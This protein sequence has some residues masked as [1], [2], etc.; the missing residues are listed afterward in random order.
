MIRD[1]GVRQSRRRLFGAIG[2]GLALAAIAG[3]TVLHLKQKEAEGVAEYKAWMVFGP[4]C[5]APAK[6]VFDTTDGGHGQ[7]MTFSTVRFARAHGASLCHD[8]N[9]KEGR[10]KDI[11][12][13]CQFDHPGVISVTTARGTSWF[14]PGYMSP[15][16]ISVRN[17]VASC[18]IGASQDFG[19]VLVYDRPSS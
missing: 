19:H 14:W 4:A 17:G 5:P 12:P 1:F 13:V 16:T 7:E 9:D 10:G 2:G 15:A 18:V 3:A 8:L 11:F 6:P